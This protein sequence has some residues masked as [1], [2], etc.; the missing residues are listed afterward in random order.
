M[1]DKEICADDVI[2]MYKFILKKTLNGP[3]LNEVVNV[4]VDDKS[5]LDFYL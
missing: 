1:S 2:I 5:L 3:R 4:K